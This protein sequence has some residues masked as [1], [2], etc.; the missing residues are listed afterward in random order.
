M[1]LEALRSAELKAAAPYEAFLTRAE[2]R[3]AFHSL[4]IYYAVNFGDPTHVLTHPQVKE[5]IRSPCQLRTSRRILGEYRRHVPALPRASIPPHLIKLSHLLSEL[6]PSNKSSLRFTNAELGTVSIACSLFVKIGQ[7]H[8][9]E[10]P[11]FCCAPAPSSEARLR[12]QKVLE[13][14]HRAIWPHMK[15]VAQSVPEGEAVAIAESLVNKFRS[16]IRS[17]M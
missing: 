8:L 1:L 13:R 7:S 17:D 10:I 5:N 4:D 12:A 3:I 15:G 11:Y 14:A 9:E 6:P 16:A 2:C